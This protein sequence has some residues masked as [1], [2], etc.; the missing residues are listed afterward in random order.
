LEQY[1]AKILSRCKFSVLILPRI[2][3]LLASF[4]YGGS[5]NTTY[6][7]ANPDDE[8]FLNVYALSLPAF[9]WFKS[10][11]STPVRRSG[12]YCQIIGKRQ[13]LSIG[14]R[15]PSDHEAPGVALDPWLNGLGVFDMTAFIWSTYYNADD[16]L[17]EQ[18][19]P[20]RQYYS[21][22]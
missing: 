2:L 22:G 17:Y 20:I 3:T 11:D 21:S 12:H 1:H 14:G 6:D 16:D 15:Q 18:P 5:T 13:M 10:N 7:W 19:E 9:K 8:G 4:I